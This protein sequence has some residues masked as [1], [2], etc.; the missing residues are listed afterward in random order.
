MTKLSVLVEAIE[1]HPDGSC[2]I[3]LKMSA[4][5]MKFFAEIGLQ[6]VLTDGAMG[7]ING[8]SDTEGAGNAGT[9]EGG[10]DPL[11]GDFPGF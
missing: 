2:T 6:K 11:S 10:S 7:V 3:Q 4:D 1:D 9:G 5:A 8:H